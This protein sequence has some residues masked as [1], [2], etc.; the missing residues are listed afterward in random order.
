VATAI[1]LR[2]AQ[3]I[4]VP[5]AVRVDGVVADFCPGEIIVLPIEYK[6]V[7]LGAVVLASEDSF[8][9]GSRVLIALFVRYLG[10]GMHNALAH[11]R[12][13][14]LAAVDPLTGVFNRRFGLHRLREEFS[15][16]ARA[17][18]PFGLLMLDIDHFKSI[19]DAYGHL[20]GDRLLR[21]VCAVVRSSLRQGDVLM[22]YGGEE[23]V[24]ILPAASSADLEQLGERLRRAVEDSALV[25]GARTVRVTVS[26]GGVA[27]PDCDVESENEI[28]RMADEA[29]YRAKESGRNRVEIVRGLAL[30]S[31]AT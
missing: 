20:T 25:D 26:V 10:L 14:Q 24:A 4:A 28:I 13:Q 19:N 27:Y 16:A 15:R 3:V 30:V 2:Q 31:Q 22:R 23:F 8:D 12:L 29:L 6:S 18:T 21:R 9:Q 5:E 11:D 17:E 7:P 1:R